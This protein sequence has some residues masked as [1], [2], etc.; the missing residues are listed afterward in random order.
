MRWEIA[1]TK[2]NAVRHLKN[3]LGI[4]SQAMY[5]DLS[6][7]A[8]MCQLQP[9]HFELLKKYQINKLPT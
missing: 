3:Y 9:T 4:L 5:S 7:L 8:A 2:L 6:E 1:Q